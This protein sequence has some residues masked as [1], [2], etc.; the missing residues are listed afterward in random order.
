MAQTENRGVV[1]NTWFKGDEESLRAGKVM[2]LRARRKLRQAHEETKK[3]AALTSTKQRDRETPMT[4][5]PEEK[6]TAHEGR[7]SKTKP[8]T[9]DQGGRHAKQ[10]KDNSSN[11]NDS[12]KKQQAKR[13]QTQK[14]KREELRKHLRHETRPAKLREEQ[15][16]GRERK[17]KQKTTHH[18]ITTAKRAL[19]SSMSLPEKPPLLQGAL[20]F[21]GLRAAEETTNTQR[22]HHGKTRP[23]K[24]RR[25]PSKSS[26]RAAGS[27]REVAT[28]SPR[29][30]TRDRVRRNGA[31]RRE[32]ESHT[33]T[34]AAA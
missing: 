31:A 30:N 6:K 10:Q 9:H 17:R 13:A 15:K 12:N 21:H 19:T 14:R 2:R 8:E 16:K 5:G 3:R 11:N 27:Y 33:R 22:I 29:T 1:V 23:T 7:G 4:E 26:S 20:N 32:K 24:R 18:A 28:S 34:T 25:R